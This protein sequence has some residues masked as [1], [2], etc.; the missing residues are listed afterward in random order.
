MLFEPTDDQDMTQVVHRLAH[1]FHKD[2]H[3][4]VFWHDEA[5]EFESSFG[6]LDLPGIQLLRLDQAPPLE[7]KILLER[8]DTLGKY[9]LYMPNAEPPLADDWL[10]DIRLY[11]GSFRAD[12]ASIVLAELGLGENQALRGHMANRS[13]F[14]FSRERVSRLKKLIAANDDEERIDAKM[15]AVLVRSEQPDLLA[16]VPS[17]FQQL[18]ECGIDGTPPAWNEIVKFDLEPTFWLLVKQAFGYD[19]ENPTLRKLLIGLL[20]SDFIEHLPEHKAIAPIKAHG[21][22]HSLITNVQVCLNQWRDSA[23]RGGSYDILAADVATTLSIKR[24]VDG[25]TA[26]LLADVETFL[27][28]EEHIAVSIRDAL[29]EG[30]EGINTA[31]IRALI[32]KRKSSH[33]VSASLQSISDVPRDAYNGI[34]DAFLAACDLR[35]LWQEHSCLFDLHDASSLYKAYEQTLYKFDS[36]Y[37]Q[38]WEAVM[39]TR[40]QGWDILKPLCEWVE[41]MYS[42]GYL[43]K[44]SLAWGQALEGG[45]IASW[46]IPAVPNQYRF[47]DQFVRP[48][49]SRGD[50]Q[51]VLVIISDAFR[52]EA[53]RELAD[54]LNS[55]YRFDA[56]VTSQ[57][58]VLP[59]HTA[60]GMAALLP[61]EMLSYTEK[62]HVF[63][64]GKSTSGTENRAKLLEPIGG[65]AI[66]SGELMSMKRDEGRSLIREHRIVYIYHNAI[67]SVGDTASTEGETFNATRKAIN[68][69]A[70]LV[71][72]IINSLNGTNVIV[73]SDHGFLYEETRPDSTDRTV[74]ID[75]PSGTVID[76]KRYLL[77][78]N[79]G[80]AQNVYHGSTETTATASGGMEFWVPKATNRFHFSGGAR[81]IHGGAMPQEVIVPVIQVRE[82]EGDAAESTKARPVLIQVLGTGF[83]ITTNRHRFQFIQAESVSQRVRPVTASI[84]IYDNDEAVSTHETVT[85]D[86]AS[87]NIADRTKSVNLALKSQPYDKKRSYYLIA[88]NTE[89]SVELHRVEVTIDLAFNNEF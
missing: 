35:D 62:G 36:A 51:R 17:L 30:A 72:Q 69:L 4:L 38:F 42:N 66:A 10:I 18:A 80:D 71:R 54:M 3:R 20:I 8:T 45:L 55:R 75:K 39:R 68:Q 7:V 79:L 47:F 52:Y 56:A 26:D 27:D 21:L 12:R 31:P 82:R 88:R 32:G 84:G 78:K 65:T 9:L 29:A 23:T 67:D 34:Y 28:V 50:N 89:D 73:T 53:A 83:K 77:G 86:S 46:Q 22:P 85:F 76:K 61:H 64:D 48:I 2:G 44:L 25:M 14:V 11:S 33:W 70:D 57:L 40:E 87:D 43:L 16:I 19:D 74:L 41:A 59:S 37:R 81:Y 58:S 1:L 13:K 6:S 49:L 5:K 15:L 63:A 24:I 60:L